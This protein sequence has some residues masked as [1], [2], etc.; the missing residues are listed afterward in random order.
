LKQQPTAT[1][2]TELPP[3]LDFFKYTKRN[4]IERE[5]QSSQTK[6]A[7][8]SEETS[9][10]PMKRRK[11][12]QDQLT[13]IF[14]R[15]KVVTKG[16]RVPV[17]AESFSS[18]RERYAFSS[19]LVQNLETYGYIYPTGIQS[20]GCPIMLEVQMS[21]MKVRPPQLSSVSAS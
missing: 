13:P 3:E 6:M 4:L 21:F 19:L 9:E 5:G 17:V 11:L 7:L 20:Q 12:E 14:G 8:R 2:T 10:S 18:L 15:Q 1:T 16:S